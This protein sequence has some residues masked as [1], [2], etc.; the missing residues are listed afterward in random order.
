MQIVCKIFPTICT[1]CMQ[2]FG[3]GREGLA[4]ILEVACDKITGFDTGFFARGGNR[5]IEE[6]LDIFG[7]QNRRIQL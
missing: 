4:S 1:K 3:N 5:I 2:H 7:Q 6:I